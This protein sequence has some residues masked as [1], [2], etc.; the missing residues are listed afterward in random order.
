[1]VLWY[2]NTHWTKVQVVSIVEMMLIKDRN[3][4]DLHER[5]YVNEV[6]VR[7]RK[8]VGKEDLLKLRQARK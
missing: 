5:D 1:M 8:R 7:I 4:D 6:A 3:T 2:L